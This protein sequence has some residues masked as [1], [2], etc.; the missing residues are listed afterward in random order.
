MKTRDAF[1]VRLLKNSGGALDRNLKNGLTDTLMSWE[2]EAEDIV[3]RIEQVNVRRCTAELQSILPAPV[4]ETLA[5]DG[6]KPLRDALY[7]LY[8]DWL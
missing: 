5:R 4:F 1:D 6:F 7:E 2:I 8:A 3:K